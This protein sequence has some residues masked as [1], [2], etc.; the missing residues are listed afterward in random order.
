[1][2]DYVIYREYE[3]IQIGRTLKVRLNTSFYTALKKSTFIS[4]T[5][6]VNWEETFPLQVINVPSAPANGFPG[7]QTWQ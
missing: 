4:Y 6:R 3:Q 2:F 5:T 1:M 7:S